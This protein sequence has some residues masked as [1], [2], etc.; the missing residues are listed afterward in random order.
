MADK[1][2]DWTI[3]QALKK[4]SADEVLNLMTDKQIEEITLSK[5]LQVGSDEV[6][7]RALS[8]A[9]REIKPLKET[10]SGYYDTLGDGSRKYEGLET[11]IT[12]ID[13]LIG[14]LNKFVL[15]AGMAGVGKS[16]LAMQM[17]LG[18]A[19]IEKIPVVYYS[20]EMSQ[21]DC[22][23]MA[24]QN[25]SRKLL[26]PE[27]ELQG[28]SASLSQEKRDEIMKAIDSLEEIS[29]RFYIIDS[30]SGVTPSTEDIKTET[31][32]IKEKH[33][34]DKMLIVID[35]IQD[36]VPTENNQTQA[37]A[38]TAQ[39]LVEL[40]QMTNATLLAIAQKNKSGVK[41]G[42]GYASVMGSVSWIHKPTSVV[43]LV[44]GFE[45][46]KKLQDNKKISDEQAEE[47]KLQITAD[48]KNTNTP[49]PI[50]LNVI[51]GRNSGYGG[52]SLKY[53]GAYR[54]YE[55]GKD[56]KFNDL[57]KEAMRTFS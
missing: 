39:K 37:E 33:K 2:D 46:I 10:I 30:S 8:K 11:G 18:V 56:E 48:T 32:K 24:I 14:G 23:T 7:K 51:K 43:E 6:V 35:S 41:D 3:K 49:Y 22:I 31:L 4:L 5:A 28:Q 15:M 55:V 38:Q 54:Y 40:Q 53:Y 42:G 25:K 16:T 12:E 57:Y 17:A 19:E 47:L 20:F 1:I 26:R 21:R 27:I 45:A 52:L 44:G 9:L 29:D 50:Y 36:V 13:D 34:A